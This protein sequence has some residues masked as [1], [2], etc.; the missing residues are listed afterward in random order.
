MLDPVFHAALVTIALFFV[1]WFFALIG[2]NLG[3]DIAGQLATFL[4]SY[5]LSLFGYSVYVASKRKV[6][7]AK[8][9]GET[10]H[11]PFS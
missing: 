9:T 11:P 1:H 7:G 2:V 6:L 4:V 10:Y 5:I 3:D 8:Y